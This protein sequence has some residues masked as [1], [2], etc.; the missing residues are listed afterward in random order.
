M[1]GS[2]SGYAYGLLTVGGQYS[3]NVDNSLLTPMHRQGTI[4]DRNVTVPVVRTEPKQQSA[5]PIHQI[6]RKF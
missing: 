2:I 3:L 1:A 6:S 5:S 4:L